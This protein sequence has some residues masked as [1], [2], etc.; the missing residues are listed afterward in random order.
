MYLNLC[1]EKFMIEVTCF[2]NLFHLFLYD[3]GPDHIETSPLI[4][5][6]NQWTGFYMIGTFVMKELSNNISLFHATSLFQYLLKK[7]ENFLF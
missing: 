6:V 3:G 7:L 4:C 1:L 5:R 2:R